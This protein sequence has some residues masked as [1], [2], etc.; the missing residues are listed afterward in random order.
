MYLKNFDGKEPGHFQDGENGSGS[1]NFPSPANDN[2]IEAEWIE[3]NEL[4]VYKT[5]VALRDRTRDLKRACFKYFGFC[6]FLNTIDMSAGS[7][8]IKY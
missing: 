7:P 1:K 6:W 3:Q 8:M 4:G 5:L 2:T